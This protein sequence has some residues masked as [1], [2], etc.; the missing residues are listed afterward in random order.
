MHS[1]RNDFGAFSPLL[2]DD[3]YLRIGNMEN[4]PFDVFLFFAPEDIASV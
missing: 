4:K 2:G 1:L 3:T